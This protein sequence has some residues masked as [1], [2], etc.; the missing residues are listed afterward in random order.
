MTGFEPQQWLRL[1]CSTFEGMLILST[2]KILLASVSAQLKSSRR[3]GSQFAEFSSDYTV[4]DSPYNSSAIGLPGDDF[5]G[6][7]N[8]M[9]S[10]GCRW[11][12]H[13]YLAREETIRGAISHPKG[14]GVSKW[15][16]RNLSFDRRKS[17]VL[18]SQTTSPRFAPLRILRK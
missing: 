13:S 2:T 7:E 17:I 8:S 10:G 15:A 3:V 5:L 14:S 12:F 18:I 11:P 9:R 16:V 6:S 1:M 4:R